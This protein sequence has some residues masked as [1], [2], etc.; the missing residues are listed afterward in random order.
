MAFGCYY[1]Y[2]Y[3]IHHYYCVVVAAAAAAA[4]ISI[5]CHFSTV[6]MAIII[7]QRSERTTNFNGIKQHALA[8]TCVAYVY[9]CLYVLYTI[10]SCGAYGR[11]KLIIIMIPLSMIPKTLISE[12]QSIILISYPSDISKVGKKVV[13]Q[14]RMKLTHSRTTAKKYWLKRDAMEITCVCLDFCSLSLEHSFSV[15]I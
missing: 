8:Y 5:W 6:H 13:N 10:Y 3:N 12:I 9:V 15:L 11:Y 4:L 7:L 2:T 14:T 1:D